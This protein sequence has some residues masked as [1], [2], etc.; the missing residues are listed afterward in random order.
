MCEHCPAPN[1]HPAI[2]AAGGGDTL[3]AGFDDEPG[4]AIHER[5]R[6]PYHPPTVETTD[7]FEVEAL[8]CSAEEKVLDPPIRS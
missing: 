1:S 2:A 4:F 7:A 5:R 6:R 3:G 8:A